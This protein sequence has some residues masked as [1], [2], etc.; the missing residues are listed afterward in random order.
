MKKNKLELYP[1]VRHRIWYP[2]FNYSMYSLKINEL[3][4]SSQAGVTFFSTQL[5]L[6]IPIFELNYCFEFHQTWAIDIQ[7]NSYST[8]MTFWR[9]TKLLHRLSTCFLL[10]DFLLRK[11]GR[12]AKVLRCSL[13]AWVRRAGSNPVLHCRPLWTWMSIT[14]AL[15]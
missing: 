15:L 1:R 3:N 9:V 14:E 8:Y 5:L 4:Q 13:V 6:K 11:R 10:F 12:I 2:D 7:Y